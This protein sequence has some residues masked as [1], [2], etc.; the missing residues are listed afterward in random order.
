[1][2]TR[3]NIVK[4]VLLLLAFGFF[5]LGCSNEPVYDLQE[6]SSIYETELNARSRTQLHFN[7]SLSG[8]N[9]VPGN[10]SKAAGEAIIRISKDETRIHFKLITANI[11]NIF[12]AHF[13]L[14]PAGSNGGVVVPLF[15]NA[16]PQP[17]GPANGVLSQGYIMAE[18]VGGALAG[19]LG[20]L[21][22]AI[23]TGNIYINVHSTAVPSGEIRG[24]L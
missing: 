20:A 4:R 6:D 13:H 5:V 12:A 14:A 1:M 8:K 7:T 16:N 18:D 9:S 11:E 15:I 17:S 3:F 22:T 10:S 2:N 19:D 23:R 24:Q 21:I